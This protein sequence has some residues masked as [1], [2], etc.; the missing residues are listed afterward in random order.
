M[1]KNEK[2][3]Y[4]KPGITYRAKVDVMSVVCNSAWVPGATCRVS[5][6]SCNKLRL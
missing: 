6:P 4:A 1:N 3:P 5:L 2:K